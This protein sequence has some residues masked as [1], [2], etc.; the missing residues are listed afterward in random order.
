MRNGVFYHH[1]SVMIETV[2]GNLEVLRCQLLVSHL[3]L[4]WP[5]VGGIAGHGARTEPSGLEEL[6]TCEPLHF[7]YLD[8]CRCILCENRAFYSFSEYI[9][10]L[11]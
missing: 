8:G 5:D 4:R 11:S 10:L 6:G 9:Y 3:I 7:V 2:N 1:Q